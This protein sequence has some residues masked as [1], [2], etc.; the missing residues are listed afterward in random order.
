MFDLL[1]IQQNF[2]NLDVILKAWPLLKSGLWLT[3]KLTLVCIPASFLLGAAIS[4]LT[5]HPWRWVR[6]LQIAYVD[7]FRSIPPLVLLIFIY[8]ALPMLGVT[9][10]QFLSAVLAI[11]LNSSSY[12]AEILRAGID[13]VPRG[14]FEAAETSGLRWRTTMFEIVMPQ[15]I[16]RTYPDLLSQAIEVFKFTSIASAVSIQELLR[17]A[18]VAQSYTFNASPLFAAAGIYI[19]IAW[20]LVRIASSLKNQKLPQNVR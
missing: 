11:T 12:Y 5:R 10:P 8:Y 18:Q 7:F 1:A 16:R 20:P 14:Q 9:L 3:L 19:L 15:A 13:S 2:F 6:W 4:V 17:N